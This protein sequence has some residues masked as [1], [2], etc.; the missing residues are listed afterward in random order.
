MQY[1]ICFSWKLNKLIII[2]TDYLDFYEGQKD[3]LL[4]MLCWIVR[5]M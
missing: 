2:G 5:L 1:L 4:F 3:W